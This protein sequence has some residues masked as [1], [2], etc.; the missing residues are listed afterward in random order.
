MS[1]LVNYQLRYR[2]YYLLI[3]L[4]S[5]QHVYSDLYRPG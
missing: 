5:R 1:V 3:Q 2:N 4:E